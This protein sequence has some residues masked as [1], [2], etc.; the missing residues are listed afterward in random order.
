[1]R[2]Q[3]DP[4]ID[5]YRISV[6]MISMPYEMRRRLARRAILQ[7]VEISGLSKNPELRSLDALV[8]K[9]DAGGSGTIAGV[10]AVAKGAT[11]EFS[12]APPRRSH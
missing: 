12:V 2:A 11:W 9:L 1:M 7:V 8:L 5:A 6:S 3:D 10:K 4:L